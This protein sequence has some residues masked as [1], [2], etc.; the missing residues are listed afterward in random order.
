DLWPRQ[1]LLEL[2]GVMSYDVAE[3]HTKLKLVLIH[4]HHSSTGPQN[5]PRLLVG[6][7]RFVN[8]DCNPNCEVGIMILV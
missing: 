1:H 5:G 4:A 2:S 3:E 7:I 8:H 6:P